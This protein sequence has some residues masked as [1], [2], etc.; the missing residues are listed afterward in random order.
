MTNIKNVIYLSIHY[1]F[2]VP[3]LNFAPFELDG[4]CAGLKCCTCSQQYL[5]FV[6][7]IYFHFYCVHLFDSVINK[8][9]ASNIRSASVCRR[10]YSGAIKI[11]PESIDSNDSPYPNLKIRLK[12]EFPEFT[13][14]SFTNMYMNNN[15]E[16]ITVSISAFFRVVRLFFLVSYKKCRN[17]YN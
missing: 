6:A 14:Y 9:S 5:P 7:P 8:V 4:A 13:A 2:V 3:R 17:E 1:I 11:S 16:P 10:N 12:F 15:Y